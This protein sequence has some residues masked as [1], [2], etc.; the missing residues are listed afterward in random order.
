[1]SMDF[2]ETGFW[3]ALSKLFLALCNRIYRDVGSAV[4]ASSEVWN[5]GC[6]VLLKKPCI[7]RASRH[8]TASAAKMYILIQFLRE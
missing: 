1:M 7:N 5:S 3:S 4:G 2:I 8:L 6:A